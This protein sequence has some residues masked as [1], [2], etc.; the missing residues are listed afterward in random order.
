MV[1]GEE[2]V[3]VSLRYLSIELGQVGI[4]RVGITTFLFPLKFLITIQTFHRVKGS[5]DS[6]SILTMGLLL[7]L[8][9]TLYTLDYLT[10]SKNE[11][12]PFP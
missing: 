4:D 2:E 12:K 6:I 9:P 10:L 7:L 5:N 8:A 11:K 3:H 1:V